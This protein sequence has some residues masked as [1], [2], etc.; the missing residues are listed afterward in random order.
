MRPVSIVRWPL[1]GVVS[2]ILRVLDDPDTVDIGGSLILTFDK[3]RWQLTDEEG[4]YVLTKREAE[5]H[6]DGKVLDDE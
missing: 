5:T 2:S 4:H 1:S 6:L 3:D